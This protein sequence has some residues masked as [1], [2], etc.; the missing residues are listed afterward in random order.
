MSSL[1]ISTIARHHDPNL[2]GWVPTLSLRAAL[3]GESE[4][5]SPATADDAIHRL[6]AAGIASQPESTPEAEAAKRA[7]RTARRLMRRADAYSRHEQKLRARYERAPSLGLAYEIEHYGKL[8]AECLALAREATE[9]AQTRQDVAEAHA[10]ANADRL[11][12]FLVAARDARDPR[13]QATLA[14][15]GQASPRAP[16]QRAARPAAAAQCSAPSGADGPPP[17]EPPRARAGQ[18]IG[19]TILLVDQRSAGRLL[20]WTARRFIGFVRRNGLPHA[21]DRR[22]VIA[23]LDD[24]LRA[25]GLDATPAAKPVEPAVGWRVRAELRLVGGPRG[26][27]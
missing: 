21:V 16:K 15:R 8:A 9:H 5:A 17:A 26:G 12:A 25:L 3:A 24:V 22:L 11:D 6:L 23:R 19:A 18:L 27:R 2:S 1:P 14:P 4:P 10:R 13:S 7:C 20:G